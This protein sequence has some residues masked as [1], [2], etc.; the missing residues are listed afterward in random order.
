MNGMYPYNPMM[1]YPPPQG[2]DEEIMKR[3]MEVAVRLTERKEREKERS[4]KIK[5]KARIE[6]EKLS[7]AKAARRFMFIET[8]ILGIVS[9]PLWAPLFSAL[10]HYLEHMQ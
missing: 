10:K 5:K 6:E 8:Y 4:E 9:Y 7:A 1:V 3:A 2:R